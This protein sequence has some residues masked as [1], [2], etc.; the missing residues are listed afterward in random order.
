MRLRDGVKAQTESPQKEKEKERRAGR[1][2]GRTE[3]VPDPPAGPA[4]QKFKERPH[5][6]GREKTLWSRRHT[7]SE[8]AG[9]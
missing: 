1:A 5:R 8:R 2:L 7:D 6:S 3:G 9:Y 4:R